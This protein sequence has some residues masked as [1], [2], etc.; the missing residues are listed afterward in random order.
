MSAHMKMRHTR[1]DDHEICR[2]VIEISKREKR[3][4]YIPLDNIAKLEEFL[5]KYSSE[6]DPEAVDWRVLAKERIE[7]Y[8][9]GGLVL[10]GARYREG[11]S[12]KKLA[13]KTGISQDNIS[14]IENGKRT[15][16]EK[17]AKKLAKALRIDYRLFLVS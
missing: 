13:E 3:I 1:D 9:K 8:K 5:K 10:R 6:E 14:K 15:V 7:K 4:S 11:I 17:V 16:G 12:Q 2:V